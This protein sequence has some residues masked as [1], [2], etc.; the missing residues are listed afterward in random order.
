MT[1]REFFKKKVNEY[2]ERKV[3]DKR[4][5]EA[6]KRYNEQLRKEAMREREQNVLAR[7]KEKIKSAW[8]ARKKYAGMTFGEKVGKLKTDVAKSPTWNYL[9][10]VSAK[11]ARN[12]VWGNS[13]V[14]FKYPSSSIPKFEYDAWGNYK[15][16]K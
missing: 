16:K 12:D 2:K 9:S 6:S 7:K 13:P 5:D 8:E 10:Q 3:Q 1:I 15:K 14:V 11:N 4:I